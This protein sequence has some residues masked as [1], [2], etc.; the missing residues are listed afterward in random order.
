M[1]LQQL[2]EKYPQGREKF[3][4]YF[5]EKLGILPSYDLNEQIV[6]TARDNAIEIIES[7]GE[8]RYDI[9]A[10]IDKCLTEFFRENGIVI[11]PTSNDGISF[12]YEIHL[13]RTNDIYAGFEGAYNSYEQ[14]FESG[15]EKSFEIY[16]SQLK[17][18]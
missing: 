9:D 8:G 16:E 4:E 13:P 14:A 17:E 11:L 3:V 12:G 10:M 7:Y 2:A 15:V 18:K 5:I 1:N 6:A